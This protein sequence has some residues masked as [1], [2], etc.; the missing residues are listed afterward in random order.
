MSGRR[1]IL[2]RYERLEKRGDEL[3][4]VIAAPSAVHTATVDVLRDLM[5][6]GQKWSNAET[7]AHLKVMMRTLE[8]SQP[9]LLEGIAGIPPESIVEFMREL[10]ARIDRIINSGAEDANHDD[11]EAGDGTSEPGATVAS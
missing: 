9:L 8:R 6:L 10:R 7:P 1:S 4:G 2:D 3:A 11:S 5:S